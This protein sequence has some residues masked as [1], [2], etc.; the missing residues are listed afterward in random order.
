LWSKR[1]SKEGYVA[2]RQPNIRFLLSEPRLLKAN[3]EAHREII[4]R[5]ERCHSK[6]LSIFV[7]ARKNERA[8]RIGVG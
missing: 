6:K 5:T 4:T 7:C 1:R 8:L 3:E 2:K